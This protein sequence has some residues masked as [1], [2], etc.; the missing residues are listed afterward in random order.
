MTAQLRFSQNTHRRLQTSPLEQVLFNHTVV[1]A[2]E[3]MWKMVSMLHSY[4]PNVWY[5]NKIEILYDSYAGKGT[6][7]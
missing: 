6:N 4:G 1:G 5:S 2:P 3:C 7:E